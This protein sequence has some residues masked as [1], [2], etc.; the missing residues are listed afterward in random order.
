ML[1]IV[2][3]PRGEPRIRSFWSAPIPA[4]FAPTPA[5]APPARARPDAQ[6]PV[7]AAGLR[8]RLHA[9]QAALADLPR[10]A[11]RLARL[12]A[13]RA[14]APK[15]AWRTPLRPGRPPGYRLRLDREIDLVL[16]ECHALALDALRP[17]TS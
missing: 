15:L 1:R 14:A 9:L 3:P 16:R 7:D 4:A 12:R 11:G 8:R 13:R 17:D 5:P 2:H 10:Q 6:A